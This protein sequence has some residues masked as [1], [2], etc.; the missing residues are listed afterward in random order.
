MVRVS[1]VLNK[2]RD[3]IDHVKILIPSKKGF[4]IALVKLSSDNNGACDTDHM[5]SLREYMNY[6]ARIQH[7]I[8]CMSVQLINMKIHDNDRLHILSGAKYF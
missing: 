6:R 1:F 3:E 7:L 5:V 2:L 8:K 4:I